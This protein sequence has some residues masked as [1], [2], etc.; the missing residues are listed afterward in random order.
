MLFRKVCSFALTALGGRGL[1][2]LRDIVLTQCFGASIFTDLFYA[3][4]K[5]P[6][7]L[8]SFLGDGAIFGYLVPRLSQENDPKKQT[9]I[10]E[11][12]LSHIIVINLI[13]IGLFEHFSLPIANHMFPGYMANPEKAPYFLTMIRIIFPYAFFTSTNAVLV[14]MHHTL[15]VFWVQPFL[16]Y[17]LDITTI[18]SFIAATY[19][20]NNLIP[21]CLSGMCL[22]GAFFQALFLYCSLLYRKIY[23]RR[24]GVSW[25]ELG[26]QIKALFKTALSTLSLQ[27]YTF[28][29]IVFLST[30]PKGYGTYLAVSEKI[31]ILVVELLGNSISVVLLPNF[32]KIK[33][34]QEKGKLLQDSMSFFCKYIVPLLFTICL[35]YPQIIEKLFMRGKF[36]A[37]DCLNTGQVFSIWLMGIPFMILNRIFLNF[38]FSLQ[39]NKLPIMLSL[40]TFAAEIIGKI[41]LF[42]YFGYLALPFV[43]CSIFFTVAAV[44]AFKLGRLLPHRLFTGKAMGFFCGYASAAMGTCA[45]M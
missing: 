12:Y 17:I 14:S 7:L 16:R 21:I 5:L 37:Q 34:L 2:L 23:V 3:A 24:F 13:V 9:H 20:P 32:S 27:A 31:T 26:I 1:N 33:S 25:S 28:V 35:L 44:Y 38:F 19:L 45:L 41:Y 10:L 29:D 42:K 18:I 15:Q 39:K 8:R 6:N 30:L 43:T 11:R 22:L 40:Y 36:N 4:S